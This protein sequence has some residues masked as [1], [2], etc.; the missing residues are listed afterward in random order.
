MVKE[1]YLIFGIAE[2]FWKSHNNTIID[3]TYTSVMQSIQ[4][5]DEVEVENQRI[6]RARAN[7][8]AKNREQLAKVKMRQ[9]I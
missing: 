3:K 5:K 8:I 2:L 7:T 9:L 1:I 6:Q 4:E